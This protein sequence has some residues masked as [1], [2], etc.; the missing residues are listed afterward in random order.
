MRVSA[1]RV[2]VEDPAQSLSAK[3]PSSNAARSCAPVSRGSALSVCDRAT[4]SR[5][6]TRRLRI[7]EGR[8]EPRILL[9]IG[10]PDRGFAVRAR[11]ARFAR[12]RGENR[13]SSTRIVSGFTA[14]ASAGGTPARREGRHLP[15]VPGDPI[16][17]PLL[18]GRPHR[19]EPRHGV[20]VGWEAAGGGRRRQPPDPPGAAAATTTKSSTSSSTRLVMARF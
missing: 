5:A 13:C 15:D 1:G 16:D 10:G 20:G 9:V 19:L 18:F 17:Q 8:E 4:S 7:Q 12:R 3:A 11:P 2:S 6:S 14:G